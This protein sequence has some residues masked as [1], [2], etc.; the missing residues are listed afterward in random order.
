MAAFNNVFCFLI[1]LLSFAIVALAHPV[2]D[3]S[4]SAIENG[5]APMLKDGKDAYQSKTSG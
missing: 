5:T 3:A 1:A 4:D 2:L